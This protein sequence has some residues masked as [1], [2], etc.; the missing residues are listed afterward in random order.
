MRI[1]NHIC[2]FFIM[3]TM[4]ICFIGGT[5]QNSLAAPQGLKAIFNDLDKDKKPLTT[6]EVYN[7]LLLATVWVRHDRGAGTGWIYDK[8]KGLII[9][10]HHVVAGIEEVKLFPP[11]FEDGEL[12]TNAEEYL[13]FTRPIIGKVVDSHIAQDLALIQVKTP[14]PEYTKQLRIADKSATAAD[15]V[16]VVGGMPEHSQGVFVYANGHV[17]Q[18]A[19][20][21]NST[22]GHIWFVQTTV[23]I[24]R[25][26]SGGAIVDDYG[27]LVGVA[28]TFWKGVENV[29][30][31]TDLRELKTYL[32][33]IKKLY[34]ATTRKQ[35]YD[36]G[37]RHYSARRYK[38]AADYF[39][40]AIRIDTNYGD[41]YRMRGYCFNHRRDYDSAKRDFD[42]A[43]KIDPGDWN[44][45][46]GRAFVHQHSGRLDQA[47]TDIS[48]AIRL[49][50][51]SK[52][53]Y[54]NRGSIYIEKRKFENA[55]KDFD[56]AIELDENYEL[57]VHDRGYT[58]LQL[59]L[60]QKA[61]DDLSRAVKIKPTPRG[62]N[63]AGV[64]LGK[65]GQQSKAL[66]YYNYA[67]KLDPKYHFPWQNIG[68]IHFGTKQYDTAIRYLDHALKLNPRSIRALEYRALARLNAGKKQGAL[69][70][71]NLAVK[72]GKKN[73]GLFWTRAYILEKLDY[74]QQAISDKQMA[75]K[76]NPGRYGKQV[77]TTAKPTIMTNTK[78]AYHAGHF[79]GTWRFR[80]K[81]HGVSYD[82][83]IQFSG[84]RYS[85]L[86]SWVDA[87]GQP[88]KVRRDGTYLIGDRVFQ[89][90]T[91]AGATSKNAFAFRNGFLYIDFPEA[92][93][94][95]GFEKVN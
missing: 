26:N 88:G 93:E 91:T 49:N 67:A 42:M 29:A 1:G 40:R 68:E 76:L 87:A 46:R 56:R 9:T 82:C 43:I 58:Y 94:F 6:K 66:D 79:N 36:A 14:L 4:A 7:E 74:P 44:S 41:A 60:Y 48:D 70:D 81:V 22:G 55:V 75:A 33:E 86:I 19:K 59:G 25:G 12:I 27:R 84:N 2:S 80:N 39:S 11:K 47:I 23:P 61:F 95:F 8:E 83:T 18:V 32:A 54:F 10:N 71:I 65:L 15:R 37:W 89:M 17:R 24:N 62:Y 5:S 50:P 35:N 13:K 78:T 77:R 72:L 30:G 45:F 57:A 92:K 85:Y 53:A 38:S 52:V 63:N 90:T 51:A 34:P 69:D 20:G 3:L 28:S 21:R 73:A 16:H 64:A 31:G